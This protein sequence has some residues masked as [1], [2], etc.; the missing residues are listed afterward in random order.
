MAFSFSSPD[1]DIMSYP[2]RPVDEPIIDFWILFTQYILIDGSIEFLTVASFLL[3]FHST[4]Y[5]FSFTSGI[6][7]CGRCMRLLRDECILFIDP[8]TVR[9][10]SRANISPYLW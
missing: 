2:P 7:S 8:K 10:M 5:F 1:T 6:K 9:A 4:G 3:C